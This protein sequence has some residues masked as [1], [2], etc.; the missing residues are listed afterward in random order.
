MT[1][2]KVSR[3][4]SEG[5]WTWWYEDEDNPDVKRQFSPQLEDALAQAY[6]LGAD[7]TMKERGDSMNDY[8]RKYPPMTTRGRTEPG[9]CAQVVSTRKARK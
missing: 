7:N 9:A 8:F 4:Y 1:E 6:S 5:Q 2:M 3:K